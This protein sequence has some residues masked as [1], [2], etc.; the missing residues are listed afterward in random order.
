MC[1]SKPKASSSQGQAASPPSI[2]DTTM[3][4]RDEQ[5][6]RKARS[7]YAS[8]FKTGSRLGDTKQPNL[9]VKSLLGST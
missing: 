8:L 5:G 2:I 9:S 3:A 4:Q 1:M 6:K 7:G